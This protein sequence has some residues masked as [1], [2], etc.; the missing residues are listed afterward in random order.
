MLK[1]LGYDV[2]SAR[3]ANDALQIFQAE[4][5]GFDL[6]VLDMIMPGMDGAECY[7]EMKKFNPGVRAILSSGYGQEGAAQD[8]L[9]HGVRGFVQKPY[10]LE[11]LSRVVAAALDS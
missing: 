9:D 1:R 10:R 5:F 3:S 8:A 7:A 11:E 2:Q 4:P 6:V